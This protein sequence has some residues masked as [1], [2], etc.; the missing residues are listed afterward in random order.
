MQTDEFSAVTHER[1]SNEGAFLFIGEAL[2]LDLVNTEVVVRG[3]PRDLLATPQDVAQWWQAAQRYY[4]DM[5]LVE[6]SGVAGIDMAML[7]ALK[8][9][10]TALRGM[11]GALAD[12][13]TPAAADIDVLNSV[14]GMGA[15]ALML[16]S[17]GA[18]RPAYQVQRSADPMQ[19]AIALSALRLVRD[20][21]RQRLHRCSNER[22][23]LLFYDTTKSA[24]RRWCSVGC[25]D[26]ARSAKRYLATKQGSHS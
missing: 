4:P 21:E 15:H 3:K 16:L 20:G 5:E 2:A 25:M 23:V 19:F 12:G 26:R 14:L 9:L 11:F 13:A 8:R 10:R 17:S 18:V 7:D 22:C 6:A 24:T 1:P